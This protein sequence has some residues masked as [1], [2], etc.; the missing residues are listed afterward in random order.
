MRTMRSFSVVALVA[1]LA[2][3]AGPA[4]GQVEKYPGKP[5]KFVVGFSAGSSIDSVAR[6][7]APH[8]Q[9]KLGQPVVVEN[10]TG[11]NG[12]L[13]ATDVAQSQPDGYTVLI[14]NSS[15]MTV[16]PSLYKKMNYDV[17]KDFAPVSLVVTVPFILTVNPLKGPSGTTSTLQKMLELAK[18]KPGGY[19][20]GSAG[21]GNLTQL[22]MELLNRMAGVTMTHVPYRG[23][24]LAQVAVLGGEIDA[25]LDNPSAV[26]KIKSG[27][28]R[29]L[30]VTSNERWHELPDVPTIAESGFTGYDMVFWVGA[31]V[32]SQTPKSIVATLHEAISSAANDPAVRAQ[33]Q[34][35]G[36]I[37]M[38]GPKPF[39]E[40]IDAE[41]AR[42]AEIIRKS[43]IKLD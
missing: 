2:C 24:A 37:R 39:T 21:N 43:E 13:A 23:S 15:T 36:N 41:T 26:P 25:A 12:M 20:Y 10:K 3:A 8:V 22:G 14:S 33:L 19:S 40:Q 32:Q 9:A 28:L 27:L 17:K 38:L 5:I 6:I 11:A 16:N 7:L 31:L 34:R 4:I 35:Q 42:Y 30:A 1:A 18:A 29:A